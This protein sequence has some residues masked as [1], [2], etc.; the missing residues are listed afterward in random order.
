[1]IKFFYNLNKITC[2]VSLI[3]DNINIKV[4][5]VNFSFIL[6]FYTILIKKFIIYIKILKIIK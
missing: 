1:M 6:K 3:E 4:M 5:N 2:Y